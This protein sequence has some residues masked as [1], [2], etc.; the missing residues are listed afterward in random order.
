MKRF[1]HTLSHYK[2]LTGNMGQ[3]LPCGLVEVLPGDTFQHQSMALI[4]VTPLTA[5]LMHP[6]N[7]RIHHFFVPHRLVFPEWEDFI[8]GGPDG[9][10]SDTIP[11]IAVP[12]NAGD[13]L[14]YM[15]V[16]PDATS[17]MVSELPVRA[18]NKIFNEYYRDEDLVTERAE[19]DL[20][21]PQIA[22]EKDYFTTCRPWPQK[23]P[24]ITLP[25]GD[26][27][28]VVSDG[29]TIRLDSASNS[30]AFLQWAGT[31]TNVAMSA[32]NSTT[33][34]NLR[35]A[36]NTGLEADLTNA[37]AV[38]VNDVRLAFALQRYE[39]ARARYGSRYTEY[40][41]YLGVTPSDARLQRP[42]FLGGGTVPLSISEVL[43]TGPD[44]GEPAPT[45]Y[46]VGDMYGHG[47]GALRG[48]RYRRFFEE[49]GYVLS[50]ISV[51]P[52][53]MYGSSVD[54]TW[55]KQDKEDFFQ[56]EL[57]FIGQQPVYNAEVM[58][59]HAS[60]LDTFGYQDRYRE[61][62]MMN[63]S[64]SSEFRSLLNYWHMARI[65]ASDPTLN[66]SFVECIPT[67]RVYNEQTQND[68][69]MMVQ[70][71]LVARRMV[72]KSARSKI[73]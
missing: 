20:T 57:Q 1:K 13:L 58:G 18:F 7:V 6:V 5:P 64:I 11:Q 71:R 2:L 14:D 19:D 31:G 45:E 27:A 22:W 54:R 10:N 53:A 35:F 3:L 36:S 24:D 12:G 49:H 66:A 48:N 55:L 56:R 67:K 9:D 28:P 39:E 68:L 60:P 43:Q 40:L 41:R 50:L 34:E 17:L 21:I 25:L 16:T 15:G 29:T 47:I 69:W 42:E 72:Q 65:F 63:S 61:Y 8:T 30:E 37:T 32:S 70:H 73:L 51:R 59:E 23:G 46:G 33:V 38:N 52:K 44:T 4:R 62:K 26:T